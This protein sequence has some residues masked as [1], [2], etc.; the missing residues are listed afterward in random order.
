G[1]G[2]VYVNRNQI[3]AIVGAQP[4]GGEGLSGTGPKAGGPLYLE[5]FTRGDEEEP[6]QGAGAAVGTAEVVGIAEALDGTEWA[7]RHDR[8]A[9]LRA[10]LR[11]RGA[12]AMSAAAAM[13]PGPLDLPGPTGESNRYRLVPRGLVLVLGPGEAVLD[14]AIQALAAGNRVIAVAP[15]AGAALEPLLRGDFPLAAIDGAIEED[16]LAALPLDAVAWAAGGETL[17]MLRRALAG[18]AGPIV[19]LVGERISPAAYTHERAICIDTTAAGGN[20]ALLAGA[21]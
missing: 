9:T 5:A 18:R 6:A 14:Q 7:L 19:P 21:A 12:G 2:N 20:T 16:L 15:G 10:A 3:G 1:A 4:F 8:N 13:D 11:G 17:H